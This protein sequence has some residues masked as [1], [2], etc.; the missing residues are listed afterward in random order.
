LFENVVDVCANSP[1][2][3]QQSFCN[4]AVR[5]SSGHGR[6]DPVFSSRQWHRPI[7]AALPLSG[8]FRRPHGSAHLGPNVVDDRHSFPV[9]RGGLFLESASARQVREHK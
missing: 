1:F 5:E 7:T 6:R 4:L 2:C 8:G 3:N 9:S